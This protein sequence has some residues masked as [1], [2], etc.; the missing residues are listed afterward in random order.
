MSRERV[1]LRMGTRAFLDLRFAQRPAHVPL[2]QFGKHVVTTRLTVVARIS[3][4]LRTWKR[5]LPRPL[6]GRRWILARERI[7]EVN[8]G[9]AAFA[10]AVERGSNLSEMRGQRLYEIARQHRHAVF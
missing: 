2:D 3:T 10:I 6:E 5:P 4:E 1:T 8:S 9:H 7:R